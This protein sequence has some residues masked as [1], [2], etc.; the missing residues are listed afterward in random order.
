[1]FLS[2]SR[3]LVITSNIGSDFIYGLLSYISVS[4]IS[5]QCRVGHEPRVRTNGEAKQRTI[6]GESNAMLR[7]DPTET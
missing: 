1:M 5:H 4:L 6:V 2:P 3:E 7:H